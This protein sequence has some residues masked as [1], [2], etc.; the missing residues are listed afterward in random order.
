MFFPMK[1]QQDMFENQQKEED[2]SNDPVYEEVQDV[3]VM[4][5]I[6]PDISPVDPTPILMTQMKRNPASNS[7]IQDKFLQELS[8]ALHRKNEP[9]YDITKL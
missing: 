7:P 6:N 8:S 3:N 9:Q 2:S 5:S 1:M 4:L